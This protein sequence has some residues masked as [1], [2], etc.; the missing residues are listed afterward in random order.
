M[1]ILRLQNLGCIPIYI[2]WLFKILL[3][4]DLY[5]GKQIDL[6]EVFYRTALRVVDFCL[7]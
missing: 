6:L 2:A 3:V 7:L 1:L 4:M 5:G